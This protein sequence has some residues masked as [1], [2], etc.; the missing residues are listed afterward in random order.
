MKSLILYLRYVQRIKYDR[1]IRLLTLEQ[2]PVRVLPL[3]E[4]SN[5]RS[6]RFVRG[7]HF[8]QL[9]RSDNGA[10]VDMQEKERGKRFFFWSSAAPP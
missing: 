3:C 8:F 9:T 5:A 2:L 1:L 7:R 4:Q 6:L 10:H